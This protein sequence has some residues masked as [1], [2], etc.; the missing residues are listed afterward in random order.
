MSPRGRS[1]APGTTL[2]SPNHPRP[3]GDGAPPSQDGW[4]GVYLPGV[5]DLDAD[6]DV[7]AAIGKPCRDVALER[8]GRHEQPVHVRNDVQLLAG[9]RRGSL[10]VVDQES[11]AERG[12][13]AVLCTH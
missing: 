9:L 7:R 5:A 2:I 13:E 10:P 8:P 1:A 3:G 11:R 4:C 6:A 12:E